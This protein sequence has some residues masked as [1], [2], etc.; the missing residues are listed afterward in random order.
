MKFKSIEISGFRAYDRPED[1]T[2]KFMDSEGEPLNFI[3]IY[4]PNGFGKT[5]FYDAV[6]WGVTNNVSRLW[7]R[8]GSSD[9]SLDRLRSVRESG[10]KID[11]LRNTNATGPTYVRYLASGMEEPTERQLKVR[12]NSKADTRRGLG[13]ESGFRNVILSQEWIS[14]FLKEDDGEMRYRKFMRNPELKATDKYYQNVKALVETNRKRLVELKGQID[15]LDSRIQSLGDENI[16]DAVNQLIKKINT[17]HQVQDLREITLASTLKE[18]KDLQDLVANGLIEFDNSRELRVLLGQLDQA[19]VGGNGVPSSKQYFQALENLEKIRAEI[20]SVNDGIEGFEKLQSTRNELENSERQRENLLSSGEDLEKLIR[21]FDKFNEMRSD[22]TEKEDLK[23]DLEKKVRELEKDIELAKREV[24]SSQSTLESLVK[25]EADLLRERESLPKLEKDIQQVVL[26]IAEKEKAIEA[27]EESVSKN[28]AERNIVDD[29]IGEVELVREEAL[30]GQFASTTVSEDKEI[31]EVVRDLLGNSDKRYQLKKRLVGIQS[32]ISEQEEL[33]AAL[34]EFIAS[35]LEIINKNQTDTCPLCEQEYASYEVLLDKIS[36]NTALSD[37][38]KLILGQRSELNEELSKLD[39]TSEKLLERLIAYYDRQLEKLRKER[40]K[41]T[42]RLNRDK[43][44]RDKTQHDLKRLQQIH[45]NLLATTNGKSILDYRKDL[46][47]RS[48]KNSKDLDKTRGALTKKENDLTGTE[49]DLNEAKGRVKLLDGEL[50]ALTSNDDYIKVGKW[51]VEEAPDGPVTKATLE[52]TAKENQDSLHRVTE[53]LKAQQ[54][55]MKTLEE[56]LKALDRSQLEERLKKLREQREDLEKQIGAFEH[57][58]EDRLSI[59]T[60]E[61]NEAKLSG[62]LEQKRREAKKKRQQTEK[63]L[64]DLKRLEK[65]ATNLIPFLQS[66]NARITKEEHEKELAFLKKS[67][68][69]LLGSEVKKTKE[70]L[71]REIKEFFY[72]E[73]IN[74]IYRKIDPH[75]DFKSVEFKADFDLENPSLDVFVMNSED[76]SILIPNLY[77]STAQINILSLSIF[78]AS[79]LNSTEYDCIFIDDPIQ[80]MDS[81]NILSTIDLLRSIVVNQDKQ[82]ILSTHDHNFHNLLKRKIPSK[83]FKSKFMELES[84]GKVRAE[85]A[86]SR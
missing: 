56:T 43:K 68:T 57:H 60:V 23:G 44:E 67:V 79:A 2:F 18:V 63:L 80:S 5:S 55:K 13:V 46:T 6:E 20:A 71:E 86:V 52:R 28:E 19:M 1:A 30:D 82:I 21:L 12:S 73:L 84:F 77:F 74:E 75:P 81:I 37:S 14:A 31:S 36:N 10:E 76:E 58:L 3:S 16:L 83:M 85:T 41:T 35:G 22:L 39:S 72:V 8:Q 62:E 25:E 24:L 51:F 47:E 78:L 66:E 34:E 42:D 64:E 15:D 61:I 9:K 65:L 11:L 50:A 45:S 69:P 70:F 38:M 53:S 27:L 54:D 4:A 59:D 26:D 49:K 48:N 33:N 32:A 17:D 40:S 29:Q 7:Q